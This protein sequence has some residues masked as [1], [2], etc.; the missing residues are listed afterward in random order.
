MMNRNHFML[1]MFAMFIAGNINATTYTE[2]TFLSPRPV[3]VNIAMEY[4]TWHDRAY[5]KTEGH[6]PRIF[7]ATGFY[8]ASVNEKEL[9]KYFGIKGKNTFQIGPQANIAA[10]TVDVDGSF[11][12]HEQTSANNGN[13]PLAGLVSFNPRQ[14]IWGARFDLFLENFP[15]RNVFVKANMPVVNV[16]NSMRMKICNSVGVKT[17]AKTFTLTDFFNGCVFET[18]P[19][20]GNLQTGLTAA[21]IPACK[22]LSATGIADV[23]L[24]LG[25]KL[26]NKENYHLFVNFGATIPTGR[27]PSGR[28]LFEP[29][30]GNGGHYGFGG[31]ID[32]GVNLWESDHSLVRFLVGANYRYL[33]E[34]EERRTLGLK[35]CNF[36]FNDKFGADLKVPRP[37]KLLQY[38]L[39]AKD[40]Q[41]N[42]PLFPAAN[43]LT[44]PL[45]ITPGSQLDALA[46]FSFKCHGFM[47]DIGYNLFWKDK[48]KVELDNCSFENV[49]GIAHNA[50][51]TD[52]LFNPA[53]PSAFPA[54]YP[55][56]G[57]LLT[58]ADLNLDAA[59][60]PS[61]LTHKIFAGIGF[62]CD[63][64]KYPV[65][66]GI[67]GSY[68]FVSS[69]ASLETY[70]LWAKAGFS[71]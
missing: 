3:G 9:G 70:A 7:Q 10:G 28:Y 42:Q 35:G 14:E 19:T 39:V 37:V 66:I 43:I 2:K 21:K 38:Y 67:G 41:Q 49:Y 18:D 6:H 12:I 27:T 58:P 71:F 5:R 50:Y 69:N 16:T 30:I 48:E 60:T 53:S 34:D 8:Q 23:D 59:R 64:N 44:R 15:I 32:A 31:G 52:A 62:G 55:V 61:Q 33:L 36:A 56:D 20:T 68:E 11:L 26:L 24:A 4:T 54:F 47:L 51:P 63:V 17:N 25:Y 65:S 1:C 45:D 57:R 29:M 46:A 22:K 40:Q 13:H